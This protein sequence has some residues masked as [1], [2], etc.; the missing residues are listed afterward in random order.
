MLPIRKGATHKVA[1]GPFP[2]VGLH[3]RHRVGRHLAGELPEAVHV[4]V[5]DAVMELFGSNGR[6]GGDSLVV[7]VSGNDTRGLC[8]VHR[9]RQK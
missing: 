7:G 9:A 5:V 6:H 3:L 2:D 4:V 8:G 1:I